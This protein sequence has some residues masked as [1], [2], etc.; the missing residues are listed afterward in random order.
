MHQRLLSASS[1]KEITI[2]KWR[3]LKELESAGQ[4]PSL[5]EMS[6]AIDTAIDAASRFD[7]AISSV[8][9]NATR[10]VPYQYRI[11][12]LPGTSMVWRVPTG[13]NLLVP[14]FPPEHLNMSWDM[15]DW[16]AQAASAHVYV[17]TF[18]AANGEHDRA[19]R[20]SRTA[21]R[22]AEKSG[23]DRPI[24]QQ[25][26]NLAH[27]LI[28]SHDKMNFGEASDLLDSVI[29]YYSM[30]KDTKKLELAIGNKK[31]IEHLRAGGVDTVSRL[32]EKT[33][34]IPEF[35]SGFFEF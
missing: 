17:A 12:G 13:S 24:A 26:N 2:A 32:G 25:M 20:S 9:G 16:Y 23:L 34:D 10:C 35:R 29:A 33:F 4:D 22:Y 30:V 31:R 7:S 27:A 1:L 15:P 18:L 28:S 11:S 6:E 3:H 14:P 21:L 8:E 19:I 5:T